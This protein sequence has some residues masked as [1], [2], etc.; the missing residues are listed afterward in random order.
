[1][2]EPFAIIVEDDPK[3]GAIYELSLQRAGFQTYLDSQGNQFMEKIS[4]L[5]ASVIVLDL[6]LPYI[7]GVEALKQ[8]RETPAGK[9]MPV[10]VLTAD[11]ILAKT[12]EGLADYTLLKPVSLSR[13]VNSINEVRWR[14]LRTPSREV[15]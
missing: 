4:T 10:I 11:I 9:N 3:L 2:N 1:M 13:L 12:V 7:S 14:K 8:I 5:P 15:E 6:H